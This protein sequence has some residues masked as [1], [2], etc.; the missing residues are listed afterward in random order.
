[1]LNTPLGKL[2]QTRTGQEIVADSVENAKQYLDNKYKIIKGIDYNYLYAKTETKAKAKPYYC[3]IIPTL[4]NARA[5]IR[6][7]KEYKKIPKEDR[8]Y[9]DTDS[10]H[11]KGDHLHK[12]K[13]GKEM[14]EFKIEWE[15]KRAKY[16][17]RKTYSIGEEIKVSGITQN[18]KTKEEQEEKKRQFEEGQIKGTQMNTIKSGV[19]IE[20]VG[21]FKEE[22]RDLKK[23]EEN[24]KITKE[25]YEQELIHI[26]NN[27]GD[28]MYFIN[29]LKEITEKM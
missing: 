15:R 28:I 7:Y 26:D 8:L 6:M 25:L 2:G 19:N 24:Y 22:T 10:I 3:P 4:V 11:F 18:A 5:R 21:T 12:F 16:Y 17:G 9:T 13:I 14:G 29:H 20:Q 1:M 23:Q 27:I